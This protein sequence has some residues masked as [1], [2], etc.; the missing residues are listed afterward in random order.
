M[1]MA[2]VLSYLIIDHMFVFCIVLVALIKCC[3]IMFLFKLCFE[4]LTLSLFFDLRISFK[5]IHISLKKSNMYSY[6]CLTYA[7]IIHVHA[8][9]VFAL[10][11]ENRY[12]Q[13]N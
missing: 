10:M 3:F 7:K 11:P 6:T 8:R 2:C 9:P 5:Y 12:S 1:P 13:G 4:S